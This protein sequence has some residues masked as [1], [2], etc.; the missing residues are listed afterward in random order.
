MLSGSPPYESPVDS[1][2]HFAILRDEGPSA[3]LDAWEIKHVSASAR[4][5]TVAHCS[6]PPPLLNPT[7]IFPCCLAANRLVR[8]NTGG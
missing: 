7:L 1:D 4:G 2:P 3:L 5:K 8:S 6:V